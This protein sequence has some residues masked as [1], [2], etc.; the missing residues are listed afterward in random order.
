[1]KLLISIPCE[2][3]GDLCCHLVDWLLRVIMEPERLG[4]EGARWDLVQDKP[5]AQTRNRQARQFLDSDN[6]VV[7]FLDA[8][9]VPDD[10]SIRLLIRDIRRPEIDVVTGIAD[11]MTKG[12]PMPVIL[13]YTGDGKTCR[14]FNEVLEEDPDAG[15]FELDAAGTGSAVLM[16]K[17]A[18]LE[19]VR[20]AGHLWFNDV[21]EDT[22]GHEKFGSRVIGHDSWFFMRC[23]ESGVRTWV[24]TGCYVGHIKANDLSIEA[25]RFHRERL[26]KEQAQQEVRELKKVK[27]RKRK[28]VIITP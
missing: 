2:V 25:R 18:A 27:A 16:C 26:A 23:Q 24:E 4:V 12:G 21:L 6:D 17:R 28:R 5:V 1:M 14:L 8:D 22:P 15:P 9:M 7:L 19:K 20:D 13:K 3:N 10:E 11:R